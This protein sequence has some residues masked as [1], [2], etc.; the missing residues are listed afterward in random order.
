MS[1]HHLTDFQGSIEDAITSSIQ[2]QLPDAVVK[3]AGGGGH[4]TIDV[5]SSGF[6][7]KSML[8]NQ[9]LVLSA[10]KHL[11]NGAAPPVHAVDSLTTRT[12]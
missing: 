9:R 3:V 1:S 7:G 2:A 6:A 8:Q 10:I 5:V 4:F 11:I 12:P